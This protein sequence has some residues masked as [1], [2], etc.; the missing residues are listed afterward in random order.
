MNKNRLI[1]ISGLLFVLLFSCG[2]AQS[3]VGFV[4]SQDILSGTAEG[5]KNLVELDGFWAGKQK[6]FDTRNQE[7]NTLQQNVM[8]QQRT[9]DADSL[10]KMQRDLEQKQKDLSRFQEDSRAEGNQKQTEILQAISQKVQVVIEEYAK[11]NAFAVIFVIDQSQA[12]VSPKLDVTAEIIK[13]YDE[14]YPSA[15]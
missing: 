9:L 8:A 1:L 15:S 14:R 10:A 13:L 6:E 7:I 4:N 12:Y 3:K 5:K 2:M 11:N